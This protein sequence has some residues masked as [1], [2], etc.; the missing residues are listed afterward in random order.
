MRSGA[1]YRRL[2]A[3]WYYI[4]YAFISERCRNI[5]M[6]EDNS[7]KKRGWL[8]KKIITTHW[9]PHRQAEL[10][11]GAAQSKC[12]ADARRHWSPLRYESIRVTRDLYLF[13]F[14]WNRAHAPEC[15]LGPPCARFAK[16]N[17]NKTKT[18]SAR[19]RRCCWTDVINRIHDVGEPGGEGDG[20]GGCRRWPFPSAHPRK[21]SAGS[22]EGE[23]LRDVTSRFPR[24]WF[25]PP[26]PMP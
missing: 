7:I 10:K 3:I 11:E 25:V 6:T 15:E 8:Q 13:F 2:N 24:R 16:K 21:R 12:F 18:G 1:Y 9:T 20:G 19:P 4:H 26:P 5:T 23:I 17:T 22:S 14:C